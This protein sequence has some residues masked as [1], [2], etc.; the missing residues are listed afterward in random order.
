MSQGQEL[1]VVVKE[2]KELKDNIAKA[3]EDLVKKNAELEKKV[4]LLEKRLKIERSLRRAQSKIIKQLLGR[5]QLSHLDKKR[6]ELIKRKLK[7]RRNDAELDAKLF[8]SEEVKKKI[9]E[10]RKKIAERKA[11]SATA[12]RPAVEVKHP[13]AGTEKDELIK[14]ILKGEAKI[15]DVIKQLRGEKQ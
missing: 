3:L 6:I 13:S 7:A 15:E 10:I 2:F 12:P 8:K 14:K 4:E 9:E 1:E 5:R 11:K